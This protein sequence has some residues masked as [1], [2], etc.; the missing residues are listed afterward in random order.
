MAAA[1]RPGDVLGVGVADDFATAPAL[2][3][4]ERRTDGVDGFDCGVM[5]ARRAWE[6][7]VGAA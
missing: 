7:M 2:A 5:D 6:E 4:D 3:D 1:R